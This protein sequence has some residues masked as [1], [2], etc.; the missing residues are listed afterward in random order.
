M[1]YCWCLLLCVLGL[2]LGGT[3]VSAQRQ[4]TV[5]GT[6]TDVSGARVADAK[7]ELNAATAEKSRSTSSDP[8]GKFTVSAPAGKY[9]LVVTAPGFDPFVLPVSVGSAPVKADA[10]LAIS[11]AQSV[12]EV[13]GDSGGGNTSEDANGSALT[14]DSRQLANLSDDDATF[15]QQLQALAGGGDGQHPPQMY[16]DGFPGGQ[17]PPKSAIRAVRINQ[18]PFSAEYDQLGFGRIEILTK[19]GT[20]KLHGQLEIFGDPSAFNSQN[21]FVHVAE[22][23]YY[24]VHTLANLSGPLSKKTSFF[25][26]ADYYDQQN[27]AIINAQTVNGSGALAGVSAAIPDP[28]QTSSYSARIDT[29]WSKNNTFTGRYEFDRVAQTNAGLSEFVLPSEGYA[30]AVNTS[31]LQLGNTQV[32]NAHAELDSKFQWIRT[33]TAQNPVSAA[34]TILV[35]GTVSDGGSPAQ[36]LHD[37]LDQL[38]FQESGTYEHGKNFVRAGVRYRLNR[39]ANLST[40]SYNGTFIFNNLA[41]YQASVQGTPSASQFQITTGQSSFSVLTGDLALW[42]E[43]E[44]K[45]RKNVTADVGFRFESQSAIPD[46]ADP[47]PH[48]GVSWAIHQTDKKPARVVLRA[49]AAMFYDRFPVGNLITAVRQGNTNLEQTYTIKNPT[50]FATTAAQL[51][52]VLGQPGFSLGSSSAPTTYRV[53]PNFR[54]EYDINAGATAEISLGKYGSVS[55]NYLL[56]RGVHQWYSRNANAPLADGTRPNGAAAGDQYEFAS[57]GESYGNVVFANPQINLTKKIQAWGFFILQHNNSD[58]QGANSFASNDYNVHQDYGRAVW[59]RRAGLHRFGCGPVLGPARGHV[60]GC[61]RGSS[62]RHHHGPG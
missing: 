38:M 11:T 41:A 13:N 30:S 37:N 36:T 53:A 55:V 2:L 3:P 20:G 9:N 15:Q 6:V 56:D 54:A 50:F 61:P 18:N 26:S 25:V 12:V 16:V 7:V 51:G 8:S 10:K 28:Q 62:V 29:Q 40:G 35:Q 49:G 33:R 42:A 32:L 57:G 59:D 58:S 24:R 43:D 21:P 47:S 60:P 52:S 46:H 44:W 23:G 14:L 4:G 39:D 1:R 22:P 45:V 34:P 5:T 27:N 31:T 17:M 19:P 48:V